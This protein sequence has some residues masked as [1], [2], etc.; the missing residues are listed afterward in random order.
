MSPPHSYPLSVARN[1][2]PP[3]G[4][5]AHASVAGNN[6]GNEKTM[7]ASCD[8][9]TTTATSRSSERQGPRGYVS[10]QSVQET[11]PNGGRYAQESLRV[12]PG[13]VVASQESGIQ[14]PGFSL[15]TWASID[16]RAFRG[17]PRYSRARTYREPIPVEIECHGRKCWRT[18]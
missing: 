10:T 6:R 1:C 4:M 15:E 18:R 12:G 5:E 17:R 14:V 2:Q 7:D 9:G 13:G 16:T 11:S 8:D 3:A